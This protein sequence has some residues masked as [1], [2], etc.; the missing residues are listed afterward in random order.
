M[1]RRGFFGLLA[2]V[3]LGCRAAQAELPTFK[4]LSPTPILY[5]ETIKYAGTEIAAEYVP[6]VWNWRNRIWE[7]AV[8][9]APVD[10]LATAGID[11]GRSGCAGRGKEIGAEHT[12]SFHFDL[13]HPFAGKAKL[14][15]DGLQRVSGQ[16]GQEHFPRS[17]G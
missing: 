9:G 15:A 1:N 4:A 3:F 13:T 17:L 12:V 14:I 11:V 7:N 10:V 2:G 5:W 8:T 6:I 16:A